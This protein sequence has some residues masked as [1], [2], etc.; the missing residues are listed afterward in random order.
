MEPETIF[1][2]EVNFNPERQ[3]LHVFFYMWMLVFKIEI[4]VFHVEYPQTLSSIGGT[5][6]RGRFSKEGEM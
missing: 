6:R 4:C 2:S 5:K 3:T 1:L